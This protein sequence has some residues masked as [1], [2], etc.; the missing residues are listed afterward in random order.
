MGEES[1]KSEIIE[2]PLFKEEGSKSVQKLAKERRLDIIEKYVKNLGFVNSRKLYRKLADDY[3]VSK[4]MIYKDFDWIKGNINLTDFRQAKIDMKFLRDKTLDV[5]IENI[6]QAAAPNDKVQAI[7]AAWIVLNNYRQDLE[8]WGDKEKIADKHEITG[9]MFNI[10]FNVEDGEK[11][12]DFIPD[13]VRDKLESDKKA[14]GSL[15][16]A[17]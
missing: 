1:P 10:K 15:E 13:N 5:A 16:K 8:A 2:P 12:I 14:K 4:R 7:S 6:L 3:K 9:K 17:D 11:Q